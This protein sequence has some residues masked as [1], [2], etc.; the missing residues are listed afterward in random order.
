MK[1]RNERLQTLL[2]AGSVLRSL[3]A[4]MP[5]N[6][7]II[8]QASRQLEV[9]RQLYEQRCSM[10]EELA[11]P[12]KPPQRVTLRGRRGAKRDVCKAHGLRDC[13]D[14]ANPDGPM[15]NSNV[16]EENEG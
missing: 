7:L 4:E 5:E 11:L 12:R 14:C 9:V 3:A 2:D 10:L 1:E 16:A 13:A 8:G 15:D 6:T